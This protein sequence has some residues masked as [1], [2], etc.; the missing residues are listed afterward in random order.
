MCRLQGDSLNRHGFGAKIFLYQEGNTQFQEQNPVRGYFS[1][2][3]PQLIF[4]LGTKLIIDSLLIIW[5][6]GKKQLLE[7]VNAD[8][9]VV[10][11]WK[12]AEVEGSPSKTKPVFL[13]SEIGSS[14][15]LQYR[16]QENPFNDYT[17]QRL[18]PQKFSQLGPFITTGDIN[19]DGAMDLFIGG[20]FNFPG[21]IFTQKTG[22]TFSSKNLTDS[23]KFEEDMDCIF[24]DSDKDGDLDLLVTGGGMQYDERS[25]YYKPRL[26][27]NDGKGNFKLQ[28]G[29]IPDSIITIAGS[30]VAADYDSDGDEDLFIGGRISK[31]YPLLPRSFLL[32]NNN[33]VFTDVTETICPDLQNAGM[34]TSAVW[35]DFDDDKK[36]DLVIAGEWMPIRFF[37]NDANK[38]TETTAITGLRDMN[39]MWR[40][41]IATD[42]DADGDVDLVA[43]NLG[44]NCEYRTSAAE[45]MQLFATDL[46]GN[47]SIDPVFF[48]YIK[49]G[50]GEKHSFPAVSRNRFSDQVPAIKKK[51]LLYHDYA[52][53]TRD[54]IL[55]GTAKEKIL[56]LQCEETRSC[57]LRTPATVN[58][59]NTHCPLKPSLH[60]SMPLSVMT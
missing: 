34:I 6:D 47:G 31:Q 30:V 48:Y 55:K 12:K 44:L 2:V 15:G 41:L 27:N 50:D 32:Q 54:K 52:K 11:S 59:I 28:T 58:S 8:T 4:G 45:P 46:D 25:I 33:G 56:E 14:A 17:L 60:L 9:T 37:K 13:F 49:G 23:I 40:S 20:G 57:F 21:K 24:F 10:L 35:T 18:L 42:I 22:A 16:H 53:A 3:D 5:P 51:F 29:A 39:G 19:K 38:L 26:Y 43:G 36:L 1:S 7:K